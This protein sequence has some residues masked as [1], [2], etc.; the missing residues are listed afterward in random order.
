MPLKLALIE[1]ASSSPSSTRCLGGLGRSSHKSTL[2]MMKESSKGVCLPVPLPFSLAH[3]LSPPSLP[4]SIRSL[5]L[6]SVVLPHPF[7]S[8]SLCPLSPTLPSFLPSC[9]MCSEYESLKFHV[10]YIYVYRY[11]F[12]EFASPEQAANAV[13]TGN[14][15]RLDKSHV[16]AVNFFSDFEK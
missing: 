15:Y 4:P 9:T 1:W 11:F 2:L 13:K 12:M 14:G 6:L 7:L 16:F 3:S 5:P 10:C 8:F